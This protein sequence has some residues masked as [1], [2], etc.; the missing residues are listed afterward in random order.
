MFTWETTMT[1]QPTVTNGSGAVT[2]A[3]VLTMIF[4]AVTA[5]QGTWAIFAGIGWL[6]NAGNEPWWP[7]ITFFGLLPIVAIMLGTS[8]LLFGVLALLAG[9]GVVR[10]RRWA[11]TVTF[12][13]AGLAALT[14]VATVAAY[15]RS[16]PGSVLVLGIVHLLYGA[17]AILVLVRSAQEFGRLPP[18]STDLRPSSLSP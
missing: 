14:G 17:F 9:L 1:T 18:R 3:G 4:G 7:V 2:A 15:E 6:A 13:V 12:V 8:F 5:A 16:D 11:R 10:R